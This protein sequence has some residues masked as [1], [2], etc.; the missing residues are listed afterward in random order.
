MLALG[1]VHKNFNM[2]TTDTYSRMT[3]RVFAILLT[4]LL[5]TQLMVARAGTMRTGHFDGR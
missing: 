5:T 1:T 3:L 4:G 2:N